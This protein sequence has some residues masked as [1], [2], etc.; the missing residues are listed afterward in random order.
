MDKLVKTVDKN[1][2]IKEKLNLHIKRKRMKVSGE[3]TSAADDDK[4]LKPLQLTTS[5]KTKKIKLKESPKCK[6]E[7]APT[8]EVD[9]FSQTNEKLE[10]NYKPDI[11]TLVLNEKKKSLMNDP[12]V[13]QFLNN[14]IAT[15]QKF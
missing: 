4:D 11:L 13:I 7:T 1:T 8:T 12:E 5:K 2:D 9:T 14:V 3:D 15:K 6:S 10:K